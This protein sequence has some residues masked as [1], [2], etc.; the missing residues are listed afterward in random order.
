M[1]T[2]SL[3][4]KTIDLIKQRLSEKEDGECSRWHLVNK[5]VSWMTAGK[6][7]KATELD[8]ID[9]SVFTDDEILTL[10]EIVIS[11]YYK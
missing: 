8:E 3:R 10:F 11:S 5:F 9:Y 1:E 6:S 7:P 4:D 2:K